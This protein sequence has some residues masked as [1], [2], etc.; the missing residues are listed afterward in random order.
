MRE[1]HGINMQLTQPYTIKLA[2]SIRRVFPSMEWRRALAIARYYHNPN[3]PVHLIKHVHSGT[4]WIECLVAAHV[5]HNKTDY[6]TRYPASIMLQ[7]SKGAPAKRFRTKL[8]CT[9]LDGNNCHENNR[10]QNLA[11]AG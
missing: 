3:R 4:E 2:E 6:G 10:R 9:S 1:L 8:A 11:W 7:N 5:R